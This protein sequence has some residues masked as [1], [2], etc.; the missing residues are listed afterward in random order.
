MPCGS[1]VKLLSFETVVM[2]WLAI[3]L[4]AGA[5]CGLCS[6]RRHPEYACYSK[7]AE[8]RDKHGELAMRGA[9]TPEAPGPRFAEVIDLHS[10]PFKVVGLIWAT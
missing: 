1:C 2:G 3:C 10:S 4:A 6:G 7:R 9:R 8:D 5:A